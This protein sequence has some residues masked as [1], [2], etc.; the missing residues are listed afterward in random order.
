MKSPAIAALSKD[1]L[2]EDILYAGK[3]ETGC[4]TY[5]EQL[6]LRLLTPIAKA[7]TAKEAV[8]I[9]SEGIEAIG[10]QGY[11]ESTHIPVILRDAQVLTIWE[12]TTHVLSLDMIRVLGSKNDGRAA[13]DGFV[14]ACRQCVEPALAANIHASK[15]QSGRHDGV[16]SVS[17]QQHHQGEDRGVCMLKDVAGDVSDQVDVIER[18]LGHTV[19][20][21]M[22][23]E[24]AQH[25]HAEVAIRARGMTMAMAALY[26]AALLVQHA[27]WSGESRDALIASEWTRE[28][29]LNQSIMGPFDHQ[30]QGKESVGRS[31]NMKRGMGYDSSTVTL[32][33]RAAVIAGVQLPLST[34][35]AKY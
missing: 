19:E 21:M 24:Q 10:G 2:N 9:A 26:C 32:S 27:H 4:A 7:F 29:L 23:G 22:L 18:Q 15:E 1:I 6:L 34:P 14:K 30:V 12:G 25:M 17:K 11:I 8:A 31:N 3:Q 28:V 35:R 20:M 5:H 33:E 13:V 16:P